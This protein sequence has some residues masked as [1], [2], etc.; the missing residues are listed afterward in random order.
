MIRNCTNCY[1]FC[2]EKGTCLNKRN[3][4][5]NINE[6]TVSDQIRKML[7]NG[8]FSSALSDCYLEIEQFDMWRIKKSLKDM[9][10]NEIIDKEQY[11]RLMSDIR[12][13]I[14]DGLFATDS[15]VDSSIIETIE[16]NLNFDE[17]STIYINEPKEF[18]CSNYL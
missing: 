9:L 14:S 11:K 2:F 18:C 5:T 4:E 8:K 17:E 6:D 16:E 3:L 12:E 13:D 15:D 1:Y 7:N 10:D